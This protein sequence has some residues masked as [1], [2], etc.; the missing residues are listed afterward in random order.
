MS[1]KSSQ[2]NPTNYQ[3]EHLSVIV[4][5]DVPEHVAAA[6]YEHSSHNP[7]ERAVIHAFRNIMRF[8]NDDGLV[9]YIAE[10]EQRI[11]EDDELYDRSST[12]L[13]D[14]DKGQTIVGRSHLVYV[15][16]GTDAIDAGFPYVAYTETDP[17]K[18]KQGLGRRRLMVMN[19][20]ANTLHEQPLHS[21]S[22]WFR[23]DEATSLWERLEQEGKAVRYKDK[24]GDNRFRF[25]E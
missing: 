5:D 16:E 23:E 1:E 12:Q 2:N 25:K 6:I 15:P 20:L 9:T 7:P 19:L 21:D 13:I 11:D 17:K 3:T 10:R 4:A 8:D 22:D 18:R 24:N 14:V